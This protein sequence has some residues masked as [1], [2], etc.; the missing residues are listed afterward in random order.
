MLAAVR[1]RWI[2]T[3]Q[4]L[5]GYVRYFRYIG[6]FCLL[7]P[8]SGRVAVIRYTIRYMAGLR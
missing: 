6:Q 5:C 3:V 2:G 1:A 4:A 8:C 7:S